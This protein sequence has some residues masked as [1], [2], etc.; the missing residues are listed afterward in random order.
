MLD[1]ARRH[2]R[3][4]RLQ[5]RR[6][7]ARPAEARP[8]RRRHHDGDGD[9][10]RRAG[11]VRSDHPPPGHHR[12]VRAGRQRRHRAHRARVDHRSAARRAGHRQHPRQVRQRHRRRLPVDAVHRHAGAGARRAGDEHADVRAR[13]RAARISTR[14]RRAACGSSSRAR[15]IWRAAGSARAGS[16]SRTRSSRPPK[17]CCVPDGPLRGQRVLVTAG[18]TYEDVDPVRY[19]GN[20]SSGRMG[21]AIAAEAAR[22]GAEVTLV[23]GPTSVEPPAVRE[24]VRVRS[25]AEMHAAVMAA[26]G[27]ART[28]SSWR[29]RSPTTRR[30]QRAPQKVAEAGRHAHAGAEEDPRHPR[31]PRARGAWRPGTGPL[32]VGF[33]A[34]T[35]NVVA[36]ATA[37]RERSTSTSS[38][39][40][41]CRGPDAGFDVDANA[42]TIVGA[43]RRRVGAAA[44]QGARRR[45]HPRSRRTSRRVARDRQDFTVASS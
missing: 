26:R 27:S 28:S 25:A 13:G 22:R 45:G 43:G 31:R 10:V 32:L 21:F 2:R 3:H 8:R 23:A 44:E 6:G 19:I 34:E 40:T 12:S 11:H 42:V 14:W 9:A 7:R 30:T 20:R 24:L 17:R 33:A 38:S 41:T 1:R 29:R 36:R 18:P 4:R 15:A 39:P 16:P 35:E 37:K 5:G